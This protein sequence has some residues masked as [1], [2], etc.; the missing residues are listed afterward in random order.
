MQTRIP[1]LIPYVSCVVHVNIYW[2]PQDE[3][4][5]GLI[6]YYVELKTNNWIET[7]SQLYENQTQSHMSPM[8]MNNLSL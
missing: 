2:L 1:L 3:N 4:A 5:Y 7:C 8:Y 6:R